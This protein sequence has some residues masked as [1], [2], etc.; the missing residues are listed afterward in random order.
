V[1]ANV[2]PEISEALKGGNLRKPE[3][4]QLADM[5]ELFK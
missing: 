2:N 1:L 4:R 3:I 5:L